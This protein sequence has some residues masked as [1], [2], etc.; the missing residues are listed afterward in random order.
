[1]FHTDADGQLVVL[2]GAWRCALGHEPDASLGR[3]LQDFVLER[4]W[5]TVAAARP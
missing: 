4:D 2:N 1:V 5:D 3:S